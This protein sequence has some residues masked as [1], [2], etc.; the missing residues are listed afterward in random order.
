MGAFVESKDGT[1]GI[2]GWTLFCG[3]EQ[4][5]LSLTEVKKRP[6]APGRAPGLKDQDDSKRLAPNDSDAD[7]TH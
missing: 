1:R 5:F 2:Q 3:I 4:T 6:D 7:A